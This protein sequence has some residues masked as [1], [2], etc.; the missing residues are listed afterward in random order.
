MLIEHVPS[1]LN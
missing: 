1:H